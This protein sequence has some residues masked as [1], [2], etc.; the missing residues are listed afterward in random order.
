MRRGLSFFFLFFIVLIGVLIFPPMHK[1]SGEEAIAAT[2][3]DSLYIHYTELNIA[4]KIPYPVFAQAIKE[5]HKFHF[6]NDHIISIIDFTKPSTEKRLFVIDLA[7]NR[8]LFES[9]VAHGRNSGI[10]YATSFSNAVQSYKSSPGVYS[11]AE[12]YQG[13]HGYSLRLDGLE[14]GINDHARERA[15]VIHAANYVSENFIQHNGRLGR[16]WGCPA[17]PTKLNKE[18]INCIKDGTCLYIYTNSNHV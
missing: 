1:N 10:N 11:T 2:N 18:I 15:I 14:K 12:T 9:L 3:I 17:L 16:S 7:K 8:L 13:K 5:Q 4:N 6:K